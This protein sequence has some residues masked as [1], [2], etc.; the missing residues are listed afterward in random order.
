M[1]ASVSAPEWRGRLVKCKKKK[2]S[3]HCGCAKLTNDGHCIA[4]C[5]ERDDLS[6][7][8]CMGLKSQGD[9]PEYRLE[10]SIGFRRKF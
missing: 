10:A 1:Q 6:G 3:K 8:D 7:V 9:N 5:A 4:I 2:R